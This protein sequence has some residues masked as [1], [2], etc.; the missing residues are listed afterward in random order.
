MDAV[1]ATDLAG[2]RRAEMRLCIL[3]PTQCA[4]LEAALLAASVIER[5]GM[6]SPGLWLGTLRKFVAAGMHRM[7]WPWAGLVQS[8]SYS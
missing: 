6:V 4:A 2:N 3:F 8:P 5:T 7:R 1:A